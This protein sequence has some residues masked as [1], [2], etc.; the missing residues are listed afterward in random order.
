MKCIALSLLSL[1][2]TGFIASN[3]VADTLIVG[4][5]REH[6]VSFIDL[7]SGKEVRRVDTGKAP[8]EVAVSPDGKMVVIV[9]YRGAGY[10]GNTL[11]VFDVTTGNKIKVINLGRHNSP[12][13]LKWIGE[14]SKVAVTTEDSQHL[15]VANIATGKLQMAIPTEAE[16]SH[17]V[18]LSPD[19]KIAYV[20]N[21]QGGSFSVLDLETGECKKVVKAGQGTEAI[22]IT[23]DGKYLW[24]GNNRTRN[25]MVFDTHTLTR[26]D[27]IKTEGIPI[28]VEMSPS[29]QFVAV[30]EADM[31]RVAIFSTETR[32]LVKTVDLTPMGGRVPV[33]L[34]WGPDGTKLWVATTM[35][36]RVLE[37]NTQTWALTRVL[38]AGNGSD[39]LGY[40]QI[41]AVAD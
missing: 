13:G 15:V 27:T 32:K 9:S 38:E 19:N 12:H 37:I 36:A 39:G 7:T 16:G 34:L 5:K 28:R 17:M 21:I 25:I 35:A 11:H 3:A 14:T 24:V 18:V 6:T 26:K 8:H 23:P 4:N 22:T 30:S 20:A 31:N 29:G 33:T 1:A 10:T 40:S 41:K 2:A